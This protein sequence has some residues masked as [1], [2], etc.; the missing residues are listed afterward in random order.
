MLQK[1]VSNPQ[2]V[3]LA[4]VSAFVLVSAILTGLEKVL[5]ACAGLLDTFKD[6][7]GTDIDNK[8]SDGLKKAA[9][10]L[11]TILVYTAKIVNWINGFKAPTP[12]PSTASSA[13][14]ETKPTV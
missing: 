2:G 8:A 11:S 5:L 13:E 14:S 6:K 1:L 12:A 4:I 10:V 7:T 9:G 3:V